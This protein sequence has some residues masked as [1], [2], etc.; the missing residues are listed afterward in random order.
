[1]RKIIIL[2]FVLGLLA[3]CGE[4]KE[5][6][7]EPK[8][9]EKKVETVGSVDG[10]AVTKAEFDAFLKFKRYRD[11]NPAKRDRMLEGYLERA[12]LAAAIEKEEFL[13]KDLMEAELN[14][15]KKEM[16][17]SRYFEKFLKDTV[18]EDAVRNY[19]NTHAS[20]YE[21]IQVHVAHILIRT[22]SK[23]KEPE[24]KAKLTTAQEAYSKV[25]SGVDF[26]KIAGQYSEDR[27]SAKKGGDLGWIKKGS[28]HAAFS[29]RA[30]EMEEGAVSEPF[31]TTFGYHVLKVLDAPRTVKRP[32]E[33]MAGNIRYQLRTKAKNAELERLTGNVEFR[34]ESDL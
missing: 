7:I 12:A 10:R 14:E 32:F 1:M 5:Q 21:E 15:F 2:L 26:A 34:K 6:K 29:K 19:Y 28:I 25:R 4:K 31:E 24:R 23:M 13:D 17:I 27:I 3:G 33:A 30:F 18:D 16:L 20:D 8:K 11:D 9:E 22:N